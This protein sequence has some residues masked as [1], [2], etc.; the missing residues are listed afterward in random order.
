MEGTQ[1]NRKRLADIYGVLQVKED[2]QDSNGNTGEA[3]QKQIT[4]LMQDGYS[5]QQAENP[6]QMSVGVD[7]VGRCTSMCVWDAGIVIRWDFPVM[8]RASKRRK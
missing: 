1:L 8:F 2:Q 6:I 7:T 3:K 5:R 4:E